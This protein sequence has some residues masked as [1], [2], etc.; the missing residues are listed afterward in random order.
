MA[1]Q[2]GV[3][4]FGAFSGEGR[5]DGQ[6]VGDES[7]RGYGQPGG[8][9]ASHA[10]KFGRFGVGAPAHGG[11]GFDTDGQH[12]AALDGER[13]QSYARRDGAARSLGDYRR[14][15]PTQDYPDSGFAQRNY[16]SQDGEG[17]AAIG[18]P[19]PARASH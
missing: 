12:G 3:G 1:E 9:Y 7:G 16:L 13:P 18:R 8:R 10:G 14:G 19:G 6:G 4:G 2:R 15:G 17:A 11:V 5:G